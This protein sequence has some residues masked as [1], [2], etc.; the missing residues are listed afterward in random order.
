MSSL[1]TSLIFYLLQFI[2]PRSVVD[3]RMDEIFSIPYHPLREEF[4]F[5]EENSKIMSDHFNVCVVESI[6][7]EGFP[8]FSRK[9]SDNEV[10]MLVFTRS[11]SQ[12]DRISSLA[13]LIVQL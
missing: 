3:P 2:K 4:N 5:F 11:F 7:K 13:S 1:K 8:F 10:L 6:I 12:R 9:W